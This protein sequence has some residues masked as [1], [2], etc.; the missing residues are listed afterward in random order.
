MKSVI[1][2]NNKL[3][4]LDILQIEYL[5]TQIITFLSEPLQICTLC[6]TILLTWNDN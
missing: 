6:K 5:K 1:V 4:K 2:D 3:N